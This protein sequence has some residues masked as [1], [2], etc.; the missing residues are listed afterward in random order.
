MRRSLLVSACVL[1]LAQTSSA[2]ERMGFGR[3]ISQQELAAWDIDVRSDGAGLP[4]GS[5]SVAQGK[6]VYGNQC[7]VCHGDNGEGRA[8]AGA[9]GGFDRLVGGAGT[10]NTPAPVM[11]VGS[12]WPYATTLFDYV[13][14]AMPFT[15]P[16]SLTADEVYAVCAYVLFLNGIVPEKTVLDAKTLPQIRM[17]NRDGFTGDPRPDVK[18]KP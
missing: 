3:P 17:P 9:A 1:A 6:Q 14:R 18:S 4:P 10:L 16:Q 8:V 5:G 2:G 11:T 15:A 7:A 13:R 12:F